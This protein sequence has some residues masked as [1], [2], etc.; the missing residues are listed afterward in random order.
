[1][2]RNHTNNDLVR[3]P[4]YITAL[5]AALAAASG[6]STGNKQAKYNGQWDADENAK[7]SLA[8]VT[9]HSGE[10]VGSYDRNYF[11]TQGQA[12]RLP[13]V[14]VSEAHGAVAEIE[15]RRAAAQAMRV[16][17]DAQTSELSSVAD[18][19]MTAAMT[20]EQIA[21]AEAEKA[22]RVVSSITD[23]HFGKVAAS[24]QALNSRSRMQGSML[25]ALRQEREAEFAK[26][27][28]A[29]E[30]EWDQASAEHQRMLAERQSVSDR[31]A[32]EIGQMVKVAE[33]TE[34]K[35]HARLVDLRNT[36]A[37]LSQQTTARVADLNQ[38]IQSLAQRTASEAFRLR[39]QAASLKE[40]TNAMQ[41][42]LLARA[43]AI[44]TS[45]VEQQFNF[46]VQSSDLA[47][48][49]VKASVQQ[50]RQQAQAGRTEA[51]AE[52][53]RMRSESEKSLQLAEADFQ[54]QQ[55]SIETFRSD[56]Q[57][58][59]FV[60]RA[61]ADR[62]E[63]DARS[64][65]VTAQAEALAS[66]LRHQSAQDFALSETQ[67]QQIKAQAFTDASNIK[68]QVAQTLAQKL[69]AKDVE[70]TPTPDQT[71]QK[72]GPNDPNPEFQNA[73]NKPI[74]VEPE[75]IAS[76]KTALA[77]SMRLRQQADALDQALM[78]TYQERHAQL[79]SWWQQQQTLRNE[80]IAHANAFEQRATAQAEEMLASAAN[81]FRRG[82]AERDRSKVEAEAR[83]KE[84]VAQIVNLR[85][86]AEAVRQRG[87]A[88]VTEF[89][90]LADA[91]DRSGAAEVRALEV[92]RESANRRG[93]AKV[94]ELLAQAESLEKSQN[95]VLAQMRQEIASAQTI[96]KAELARLDQSAQSFIAVAKA[97]FDEATTIADTFA[98][99][100][101]IEIAQL[102]AENE[103]GNRMALADI[104]HQRNVI[105]A[106]Q[107]VGEAGVDRMMAQANF[108]RGVAEAADGSR[109]AAILAQAQVHDAA[110]TAQLASADAS[111]ESVRARFDSRIAQVQAERNI[112]YAKK[113]L[114]EQE[115]RARVEQAVAASNAYKAMSNQ[116]LA[117]LSN[118]TRQFETAAKQNWDQRLAMPATYTQPEFEKAFPNPAKTTFGGSIAEVP[119]GDND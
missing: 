92:Q 49:Q 6:C 46:S 7:A 82:E 45:G 35:T 20:R 80:A 105:D 84:A 48:D 115:T 116:A 27:R 13:S 108:H 37:Q 16:R 53:A 19:D 26:M 38:Q 98:Q 51:D 109:R 79:E 44:E 100:S 39:E 118:R 58:E 60:V 9:L 50:A 64:K 41:A 119:T 99:K 70:F 1:M 110:I 107:L 113:Y 18:A 72:T 47:F 90:S 76:F 95:A 25:A 54:Q 89:L 78:A 2:S 111:E 101:H 74:V 15:A 93:D 61:K 68:A 104:N 114:S 55:A 42:E 11:N 22:R 88:K 59:V 23:E 5:V 4:V 66:A 31:G 36:S 85:A 65:F 94:K 40:Q 96:L 43:G 63:S 62:I 3:R 91:T 12:S 102:H 69:Q 106:D 83:R 97:S 10:T 28:S 75:H 14:W 67:F 34:S 30:T 57:S 52:A 112:A 56:G 17:R 29:A 21:L 8:N 103:S 24:E 32:A 86:E 117:G 33:M 87:D 77:D 71:G 73:P 81:E